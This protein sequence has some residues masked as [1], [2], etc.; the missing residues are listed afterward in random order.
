MNILKT[1]DAHSKRVNLM[2]CKLYLN[3]AGTLKIKI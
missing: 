1:I 2:V 3:N